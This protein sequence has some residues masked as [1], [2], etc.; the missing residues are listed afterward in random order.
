M[1]DSKL[2]LNDIIKK[3]QNI[4]LK[5]IDDD[6]ELSDDIEK[7][8]VENDSKLSDKLDGYENFSRY[9]RS[10]IDYL[11]SVEEHY[12]KRRKVL[13][14]SIKILKDRMLNAMLITGKD[15]IKTVEYNFSIGESEKWELDIELLND[16]DKNKL[17]ENGLA[18]NVFKANINEIKNKYKNNKLPDWVNIDK[19]KFLRVK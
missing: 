12:V 4:E 6:G 2:T 14:N 11:K 8:I 15:K 13:E 17:I 10:Q 9:L 18:E 16:M 1:S 3:F 19:N 5:L 7:M